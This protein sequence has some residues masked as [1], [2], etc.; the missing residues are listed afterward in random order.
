MIWSNSF[1]Y[2]S[3]WLWFSFTMNGNLCAYLRLTAPSTPSV[4]AKALQPPSTA[5]STRF[6]GSK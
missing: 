3:S 4:E 2:V 5:S 1:G 6:S